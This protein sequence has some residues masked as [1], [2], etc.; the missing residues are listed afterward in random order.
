[1][2]FLLVYLMAITVLSAAD[3][4]QLMQVQQN[5]YSQE[6]VESATVMAERISVFQQTCWGYF[7]DQQMAGYLLA[8]PSV[9]GSITPLAAAF[10]L[11]QNTNCLY[12]HDMAISSEFRGQ[13]LAPKLLQHARIEAEKMG[14][15]T[16]ALVAVQGADE[17]WAKQGFAKVTDISADQQA[18]LDTYLPEIACYMIKQ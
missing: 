8:Y 13:S 2:A 9:L 18:I 14:L 3:V 15:N 11:Y 16:M 4:P 7:V 6:L 1:V 17:Y 12:L 5:C 10:P